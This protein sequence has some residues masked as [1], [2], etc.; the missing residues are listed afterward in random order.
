[1]SAEPAI[2]RRFSGVRRSGDS[3][4]ARC[5][6]HDDRKASLSIKEDDG[7]ILLH[8]HAGCSFEA[9]CRAAGIEMRDLFPA[10]TRIAIR[11][12]KKRVAIYD[13]LN[14]ARD[15]LFQVLR[16]EPK[17]FSQRRP[18]GQ[19][20]W[21]NNLDG[22]R[23]VTYRLPELLPAKDVVIVEGEKDVETARRLGIVATCNPGGAGKWRP[24]FSEVLVG[25]NIVVI[26]DA[27]E[28]GRAHA[29]QVLAS[30]AGKAASCKLLELPGTKDLS[31]WTERGGIREQ[32]LDLITSAPEWNPPP[33]PD[34]ATVLRELERFISGFVVLPPH[35]L[36]PLALWA[37]ATHIFDVFDTY[38]F[39][40]FSSPA[41]RCGKTRTL[42]VLELVVA[43]PRRTA[44]VSEAALFRLVDS[45][46]PTF[47]LD[48]QEALSGKSERAEA[49][50]GLLNA[51]HR[52]GS[53]ATRCGGAN[54]DEVREFDVYCPKVLAGI[55]DFQTTLRDRAIVVAM[56]RRPAAQLVTRFIHR[57]ASQAGANLKAQIESW[58]GSNRNRIRDFYE[59]APSPQFLSDREEE[60]WA[61][62]FSILAIAEHSRLNELRADAEVLLE[63][64]AEADDEQTLA[65]EILKHALEAWL[66]DESTI[67]SKE[68]IARLQRK[69]DAPTFK[70]DGGRS[71]VDLSPR[72]LARMIRGFGVR[73]INIRSEGDRVRKG[74]RRSE[75]TG[76]LAPYLKV[77]SATSAT[78]L[79]TQQATPDFRSA[80]QGPVADTVLLGSSTKYNRVADVADGTPEEVQGEVELQQVQQPRNHA[81]SASLFDSPQFTHSVADVGDPVPYNEEKK[82][83]APNRSASWYRPERLPGGGWQ[84]ECGAAITDPIEWSRHTGTGG[85]PLKA[86]APPKPSGRGFGK[87]NKATNSGG[88]L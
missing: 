80:T 9:V 50:R 59:T 85:C 32:L 19:G 88:G 2:L 68:L 16:Y 1:M 57:I 3:W 39:L 4:S 5:P 75:L 13:Y 11:T 7:K 58:A 37:L 36:L 56:Q 8:C 66:P 74:Y 34:G 67:T 33:V 12:A 70:P 38:P 52:R 6:A 25:K 76:A 65:L 43:R 15:L 62:L 86:T 29:R 17:G 45:T 78:S 48:E 73:P 40:I 84:C 42:E 44:N 53:K 54:R 71:E 41:P 14:E 18:D 30:I 23:R 31:E 22:V 55:G 72:R 81:G 87:A 21:I 26:P 64:K 10:S 35:T 82:E 60:N 49:L 24:E 47:L 63:R 77:S 46:H 20:G 79:A 51:G 61:P 83:Q 69:E 28:P 27:D